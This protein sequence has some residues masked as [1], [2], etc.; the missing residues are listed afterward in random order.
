MLK[1]QGF[2]TT[3]TTISMVI[4]LVAMHADVQEKIVNELQKVFNAADEDVSE[5]K[6]RELTYLDMVVQETMR[7]STISSFV[8]RSV[9][10]EIQIGKQLKR[11]CLLSFANRLVFR[12]IPRSIRRYHHN[13][14][15]RNSFE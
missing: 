1:L 4:L 9:S 2:E 12:L 10:K 7:H 8:A 11:Q 13:P 15:Q 6:L 5:E 3:S 14:N